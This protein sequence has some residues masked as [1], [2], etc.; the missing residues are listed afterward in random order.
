[1]V[2]PFPALATTL[3]PE[4]L[5]SSLQLATSSHARTTASG[6]T[7]ELVLYHAASERNLELGKITIS[8][9][10]NISKILDI[11]SEALLE[12]DSAAAMTSPPSTP[13]LAIT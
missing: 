4:K 6:P 5:N 10:R 13:L 7:G 2:A 11:A 12:A 8:N 9:L 1:M 3:A